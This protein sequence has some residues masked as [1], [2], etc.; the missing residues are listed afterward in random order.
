MSEKIKQPSPSL[1]ESQSRG[2]DINEAGIAFQAAITLSYIPK[3]LAMEGFTSMV[4]EGLGD[5]EAKLFVPGIGLRNEFLEVKDHS[6]SP[7]EFW[8]EIDRFKQIDTGA[9]GDYQWF[10]LATTGLSKELRPLV[11][12]LRRIRG[13][14]AFYEGSAIM[15]Q[16]YKEYE[17]VVERLEKSEEEAAFL[18]RK[19]LVLDDLSTN[20]SHAKALFKQSV[21]DHL[22]S[23]KNLP[24]NVLD[25]IYESLGSFV[26]SRRNETILRAEIEQTINTKIPANL[27]PP[28]QPVRIHTATREDEIDWHETELQFPWSKFSGGERRNYPAPEIWNTEIISP[29]NETKTW[30]LKHRKTRRIRLSG[31]RRLSTSL[32]FGAVFSAVSGFAIDMVYRDDAIWPT[33]SHAEETTIPYEL[34][35]SGTAQNQTGEHL[36]VSV[37][38]LRD[39]AEEVDAFLSDSNLTEAPTLHIRGAQPVLTANQ[40]NLIVGK[41]KTC[42]SDAARATGAKQIELF[43]AGPAFLALF[44]GHRLNATIGRIQCYERIQPSQYVQTCLLFA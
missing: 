18:Y 40:A 12:S 19:V 15:D 2:G 32:A 9:P 30:I 31:S 8:P 25:D 38:I 13:P 43:F 6:L 41:I 11:N 1:L 10:T 39:I 27:K 23:H 37:A 36:V 34:L 5:T 35:T 33:D 44:L 26:L 4:R 20:R 3:W 7:S 24:D 28:P 14:Y 16:S 21:R 22:G 42:M 29:L 17:G